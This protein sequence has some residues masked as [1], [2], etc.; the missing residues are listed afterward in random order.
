[1]EAKMVEK[2][3]PRQKQVVLRHNG[4]AINLISTIDIV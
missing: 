4:L 3:L 2:T 1:M